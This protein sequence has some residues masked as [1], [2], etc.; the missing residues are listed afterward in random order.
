MP[1]SLCPFMTT[2]VS[3]RGT[4]PVRADSLGL[5]QEPAKRFRFASAGGGGV[6]LPA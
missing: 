3:A 5:D 2:S 6:F 4:S 1:P